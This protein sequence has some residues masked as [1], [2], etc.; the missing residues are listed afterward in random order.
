MEY[1]DDLFDGKYI[2]GYCG[3]CK[4]PVYE[5]DNFEHEDGKYYHRFCYH[6]MNLYNEG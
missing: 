5:D 6:Q 2:I 4:D 3:Y 1:E